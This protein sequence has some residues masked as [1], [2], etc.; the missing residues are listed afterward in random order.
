LPRFHWAFFGKYIKPGA[1]IFR[2]KPVIRIGGELQK[3]GCRI[4]KLAQANGKRNPDHLASLGN[5]VPAAIFFAAAV[6]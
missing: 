6:G 4:P 3:G 1:S 2:R 5:L